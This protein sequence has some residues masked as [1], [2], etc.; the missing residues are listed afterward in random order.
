MISK[1]QST[2]SISK[3]VFLDTETSQGEDGLH[4]LRLGWMCN[5]MKGGEKW[6]YFTSVPQ[7]WDLLE[8][9]IGN[10]R[11]PTFVYAYNSA[12]DLQILGIE[13][14]MHRP[15]WEA[16]GIP[17]L[18]PFIFRTAF[19]GNTVWFLDAG[20]H[21]GGKIPLSKIGENM[22]L[23]KGDLDRK[24]LDE[25]PDIE[26]SKYCRRDV[27]ITR[28]YILEWLRFLR[29]NE[30]GAYRP[31][32]AAQCLTAYRARFIE[33][34]IYVHTIEPVINLERRSYRGGRVECFYIG[35]INHAYKMDVNS[36]HPYIMRNLPL[37]YRLRGT[38]RDARP[39][40]LSRLCD[41]GFA[42]IAEGRVQ[43]TPESRMIPI[44]RTIDKVDTN[45]YPIGTF[46]AVFTSIDYLSLIANGGK[47]LS[48]EKVAYYDKDV[49][50]KKYIDFFYEKRL[51]FKEE[52]NK[53]MEQMAK[54]FMN[55][56]EGKFAQKV[57]QTVVYQD[58]AQH[59]RNYLLSVN[60]D[61]VEV[62]V[63]GGKEWI[64]V[65]VAEESWNTFIPISSF[66]RSY[67]RVILWRDMQDI[68]KE[69]GEVYYCDTD[70]LF[71]DEKGYAALDNKKRVST[72]RLG[73]YKKEDEGTLCIRG[74][75]NYYF[76]QKPVIK[77][78]RKDAVE[79]EPGVFRQTRF[80]AMGQM[81]RKGISEG[82]KIRD[83]FIIRL[84]G[85]YRKGIIGDDGW[86]L[87][88]VLDE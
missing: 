15:G 62:M 23:L 72:S 9:F 13:D 38:L 81:R 78:I 41:K 12:F 56:L 8:A 67:T 21:V 58:P 80:E 50:F 64:T 34:P 18:Q 74:A 75:K 87:P 68:A 10:R 84:S 49:L 59:D 29:E 35:E 28:N 44:R 31:S 39:S 53:S 73:S 36:F 19:N 5:W 60:G 47:V 25:Y 76:N 71:C 40:E 37:P 27:E 83:D 57:Q 6:H 3:M 61:T 65:P 77:G 88:F 16:D 86:V 11:R 82:V 1:S 42:F 54:Y 43:V 66:I 48:A 26:V 4:H 46:R 85:K 30:L 70:S 63:Y 14:A 33:Q 7:F 17:I 69:G 79:I 52:G 20:N 45:I 2:V 32:L 51:K 55:S 22:D 24:R